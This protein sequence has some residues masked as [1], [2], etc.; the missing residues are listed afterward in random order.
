MRAELS[1]RTTEN[2][3]LARLQ[4]L[5]ETKGAMRFSEERG[6]GSRV[7][8][9]LSLRRDRSSS[10]SEWAIV[11]GVFEKGAVGRVRCPEPQIDE[12]LITVGLTNRSRS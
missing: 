10:W 5:L 9:A 6:E 3:A 2:D 8:E 12:I 11:K 4:R 1:G 7:E